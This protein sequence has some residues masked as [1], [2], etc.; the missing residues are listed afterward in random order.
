MHIAIG[1]RWFETAAGNHIE[2]AL[3]E[4]G[5]RVDYVGL[6][7]SERMGYDGALAIDQIIDAMSE[8]PDLYLWVDP[9]GRYFPKG[10][11]N[12]D[13]PTA[14]YLID[15]HIGT[16]REQ[17]ASFFDSVF[18]AQKENVDRIREVVGHDQVYWLPLAA[19]L[20]VHGQRDLPKIY[21]VGFVGNLSIAHRGTA[22]AR[23]LKL[24][25]EQFK[26]NDFVRQYTPSEVGA[27]YSQSRIVFNT[28][29]AGDV[30]MRV[31]EGSAAGALVV[32]DEIGNGLR[33][34]FDVGRELVTYTNDTDL[35][36][37]VRYYLMHEEQRKS[38]A[39][40]GQK[41]TVSEHTYMHRCK[42]ILEIVSAPN[43]KRSAPM[44][45]ASAIECRT[46]RWEVYTHL[47]MLDAL[48][49]EANAAGLNPGQKL[50]AVWPTLL[51]RLVR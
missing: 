27:V 32:T 42:R 26:T 35:I 2:R 11:E 41:R 45:N 34:L 23:R 6:P 28:S 16:W 43:V 18:V 37:Q 38:I 17:V 48:F 22:R 25:T 33:E 51:R 49:D 24:L 7:G 3:R 12:L 30:N 39:L 31:F 5:H 20:D 19:A 9:A 40:A 29:L 36:E 15:V 46:A 14:C 50:C 1:Y 13:I 44:R 8:Q 21:D 47:H 4:L 10:I